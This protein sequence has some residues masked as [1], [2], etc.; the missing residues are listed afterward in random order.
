MIDYNEI[1]KQCDKGK[2]IDSTVVKSSTITIDNN[3]I[4]IDF[5]EDNENIYIFN[6]K[7]TQIKCISHNR[8]DIIEK[9]SNFKF[10]YIY[11]LIKKNEIFCVRIDAVAN[12]VEGSYRIY[13]DEI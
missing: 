12:T 1:I 9:F 7:D 6:L 8:E 11:E 4:S 10:L 3:S 5:I 13:L 2:A